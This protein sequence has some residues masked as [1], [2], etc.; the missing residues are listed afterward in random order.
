MSLITQNRYL[1]LVPGITAPVVVHCSF[2]DYGQTLAFAMINGD[3][4]YVPDVLTTSITCHG[5]RA[6]GAGIGPYG[7]AVVN[8]NVTLTLEQAMTAVQGPVLMELTFA[9]SSGVTGTANFCLLVEE[10]TFPDGVTYDT[11]PSVYQAILAY[12]MQFQAQ[13][14]NAISSMT[15]DSEVVDIRIGAD[16]DTYASAGAAVRGQVS[17][18][19]TMIDI[20]GE[21]D[22]TYSGLLNLRWGEGGLYAASGADYATPHCK[23]G[24]IPVTASRS[25]MLIN[26]DGRTYHVYQYDALQ[27]MI[28][29]R[30][31]IT[32]ASK[33]FI[34]SATTAY[35]RFMIESSPFN[36][37][38]AKGF[39]AVEI[40]SGYNIKTIGNITG[41][42]Y[43]TLSALP[44]GTVASLNSGVINA[45]SDTPR[46]N[47][48]SGGNVLTL[49]GS[50]TSRGGS[51]QIVAYWD[52]W[53]YF[54]GYNTQ[55]QSWETIMLRGKEN[56]RYVVPLGYYTDNTTYASFSALPNNTMSAFNKASAN[57]M[58]DAPVTFNTGVFVETISPNYDSENGGIQ[59]I[60]DWYGTTVCVR[61]YISNQWRAWSVEKNEVVTEYTVGAGKD[62]ATLTECL[63][64]I[65]QGWVH[66]GQKYKVYVDAGTYDMTDVIPYISNNTI[67]SAGF[68]LPPNT[69][70]IGKGKTKTKLT[71]EYT[72]GDDDIQSQLAPINMPYGGKLKGLSIVVKNVRYA[73]HTDTDVL[74]LGDEFMEGNRIEFED[75]YLEHQ[76][77]GTGISPTYNAPASFGM[78]IWSGQVRTFRDCVFVGNQYCAWL[79]HNRNTFADPAEL[80]FENCDFISHLDSVPQFNSERVGASLISWGAPTITRVSMKNCRTNRSIGMYQNLADPDSIVCDYYVTADNDIFVMQ[81]NVNDAYKEDT[82]TTGD[83]VKRV[84]TDVNAVN[85]YTPVGYDSLTVCTNDVENSQYRGILL[86]NT[87]PDG[88]A[89]IQCKGLIYSPWI[90][91]HAAAVG[92]SYNWNGS[93][94]EE[95]AD[96]H[97]FVKVLRERVAVINP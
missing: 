11:D 10:A 83:C 91:L 30:T 61:A 82:Y 43:S 12:V 84:L 64:A 51:I 15:V 25:Y 36:I 76:G 89:T 81:T 70:I 57:N 73:I 97:P 80:D 72:G 86:H 17:D 34:T 65:R 78:G 67:T 68:V 33:I 74:S 87:Q 54:R 63:D 20:D 5:V 85:A 66:A 94:W 71:L 59:R 52:G 24:F 9:D 50:N 41:S 47:S 37:D 44:V 4:S 35:V 93:S 69:E 92:K 79:C 23:T 2:G 8:G 77:F 3:D 38:D 21:E 55:Y 60:T 1:N 6:D 48:S 58:A 14:D 46:A 18:L 95:T 27:A 62:Y 88:I 56:G 45:M 90:N 22:V 13:I 32:T 28:G 19:D 53:L 16:G 75:L 42:D 29:S 31:T 40:M 96:E 49:A 7:C 39:V 26:P